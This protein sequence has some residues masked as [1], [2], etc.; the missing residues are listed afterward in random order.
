MIYIR[1]VMEIRLT[2]NPVGDIITQL[3]TDPDDTTG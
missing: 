2:I 1:D 3:Y